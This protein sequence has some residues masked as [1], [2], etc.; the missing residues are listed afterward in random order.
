M[1]SFL[2]G[3]IEHIGGV[4]LTLH[5]NRSNSGSSRFLVRAAWT[6]CV[7]TWVCLT[8]WD[9]AAPVL[10]RAL[11]SCARRACLPRRRVRWL[12]GAAPV[13]QAKAP[14]SREPPTAASALPCGYPPTATGAGAP[15]ACCRRATSAS[16][17]AT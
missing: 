17:S 16:R 9:S 15:A 6:S 8:L 14:E 10:F 12:A 5:T 3:F 4:L 7:H 2:L 13:P 1:T 11:F